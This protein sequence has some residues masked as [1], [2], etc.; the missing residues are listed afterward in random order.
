L[1]GTAGRKP[2]HDRL[3]LRELGA[4]HAK[5]ARDAP[6]RIALLASDIAGSDGRLQLD[7]Q[8]RARQIPAAT[9]LL[10]ERGDPA[11]ERELDVLAAREMLDRVL[12]L[13]VAE[14]HAVHDA[15]RNSHFVLRDASVDL[16]D[17]P[18]DLERRLEEQPADLP[19]GAAARAALALIPLVADE[20]ADQ[21]AD[22]TEYGS[23]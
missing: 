19:H 8:E 18:H 1:R 12:H 21:R 20:H 9:D 13:L 7:L 3:E 14:A 22:G 15:A 23:Y 16:R 10:R 17:S 5:R 11:V 6:Q 4:A 2:A